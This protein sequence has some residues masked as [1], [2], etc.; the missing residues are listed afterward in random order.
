[1]TAGRPS[2]FTSTRASSRWTMCICRVLTRKFLLFPQLGQVNG[3]LKLYWLDQAERNLFLVFVLIEFRRIAET[4]DLAGGM[5]GQN[6]VRALRLERDDRDIPRAGA[7]GRSHTPA[8]Q[9]LEC[10]ELENGACR[11]DGADGR[12]WDCHNPLPPLATPPGAAWRPP[13]LFAIPG[14]ATRLDILSGVLV[15]FC[16][17]T[18]EKQA[19][20]DD[21][22]VRSSAAPVTPS[23]DIGNRRGRY[24]ARG[25]AKPLSPHGLRDRHRNV[26]R[27]A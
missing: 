12:R 2:S 3:I 7:V 14:P 16:S 24:Y 9:A 15:P 25:F 13:A 4:E 10:F 19:V 27:D 5:T 21:A 6:A 23:G 22:P 8:R 17:E 20:A 1:M 26:C 11:P 18:I